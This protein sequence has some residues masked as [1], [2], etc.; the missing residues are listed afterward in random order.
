M[1]MKEPCSK[2]TRREWLGKL[3]TVSSACALFSPEVS[4]AEGQITRFDQTLRLR[5]SDIPALGDVG[6]SVRATYNNWATPL[7]INRGEADTFYVVDPTCTHAGCEVDLYDHGQQMII[8]PCHWSTFDIAGRVTGAPAFFDLPA[9]ACHY[10]AGVLTIEIPGLRFGIRSAVLVQTTL[11]A[12][13]MRLSFPT[14][15]FAT[16]RVRKAAN[17]G[18]DFQLVNFATQIDGSLTQTFLSGNGAERQ[19]FVDA[20]GSSAFYSLELVMTYVS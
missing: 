3:L 14:L 18:G 4:S 20:A 13:R 7:M 9:Y 12:T 6:G 8:C 19:V 1:L 16:Y 2:C 11:G 17:L 5:V 15:S 10:D